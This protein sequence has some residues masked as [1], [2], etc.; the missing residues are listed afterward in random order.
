MLRIL[1]HFE[2]MLQ[3]TSVRTRSRIAGTQQP[4]ATST[5][6]FPQQQQDRSVAWSP[7]RWKHLVRIAFSFVCCPCHAYSIL[8]RAEE[9]GD[10]RCHHSH[11]AAIHTTTPTKYHWRVSSA[12]C[13]TFWVAGAEQ[14]C[15]CRH[16]NGEL[17]P[18]LLLSSRSDHPGDITS[19]ESTQLPPG[20]SHSLGSGLTTP[21]SFLGGALSGF[22]SGTGSPAWVEGSGVGGT[23]SSATAITTGSAGSDGDTVAEALRMLLQGITTLPGTRV[24]TP[25]LPLAPLQGQQTAEKACK[26]A[27]VVTPAPTER[28]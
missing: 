1:S 24:P 26:E 17:P 8:H 7:R 6:V 11:H 15:C 23:S 22:N 28:V 12:P 18:Q 21:L 9:L 20:E 16:P 19:P 3:S 27:F 10:D 2:M 14:S 5:F 25:S 4:S 13:I